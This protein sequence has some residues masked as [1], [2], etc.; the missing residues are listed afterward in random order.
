MLRHTEYGKEWQLDESKGQLGL[1]RE[2]HYRLLFDPAN[3]DES[4]AEGDVWLDI[5]AN[6]GAFAI[7][8]SDFVKRV[9]AVEP[10]P[11]NLQCLLRNMELNSVTNVDVVPAAINGGPESSVSLALSNTFSSTHR[12]GTIRGRK[13][14]EVRAY[15]IDDIVFT[16]G[17]NKIKMDCEGSEAEI[18]EVMTFKPIQEIIFEYHFSFLKDTNWIRFYEI[19]DRL[20]AAGFT[21]LKE[22]KAR[23][24]T[25]HTI[26]WAKRL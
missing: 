21:I 2:N 14:I 22:P 18:L 1:L 19:L 7:R 11:D 23:S 20:A 13:S 24:K 9:V 15:H 26:V 16:Y 4:L 6:I 8:A 3:R 10:E 17:V 12:I 5:G 25:W